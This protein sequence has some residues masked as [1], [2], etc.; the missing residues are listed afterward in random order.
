MIALQHPDFIKGFYAYASRQYSKFSFNKFFVTCNKNYVGQYEEL[1][2][3]EKINVKYYINQ[4]KYTN[5]HKNKIS[6]GEF[7]GIIS[8]EY[9]MIEYL[10]PKGI[11][12]NL[13]QREIPDVYIM[14]CAFL[15][16]NVMLVDNPILSELLTICTNLQNI[17][18][19]YQKICSVFPY[20]ISPKYSDLHQLIRKE[21]ELDNVLKYISERKLQ[22]DKLDYCAL[23]SNQN[24]EFIKLKSSNLDL[25]DFS[26]VSESVFPNQDYKDNNDEKH[27]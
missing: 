25:I 4:T 1:F 22:M 2:P 21:M 11:F 9:K 16:K 24:E 20:S 7:D 15:F 19:Q 6:Y 14:F 26:L 23:W 10:H 27:D 17:S 5:T 13:I 8:I 18:R 12:I 3:D